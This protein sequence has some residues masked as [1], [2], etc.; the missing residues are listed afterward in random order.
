MLLML[1]AMVSSLS[2]SFSGTVQD[3]VDD[4]IESADMP[5]GWITTE[6]VYESS[7]EEIK[8]IPGVKSV[9]SSVILPVKTTLPSGDEF[10]LAL[11]GVDEKETERFYIK[12]ETLTWDD[13]PEVWV[14]AYFAEKNGVKPGNEM[15]L[16][17]GQHFEEKV[18][19]RGLVSIPETMKCVR[20]ETSWG[21]SVGYGYIYMS[22]ED[23]D[24]LF[25]MSGKANYWSIRLEEGL[26][27]T[28]RQK[29]MDAAGE[30]FGDKTLD[31]LLYDTSTAKSFIDDMMNTIRA[32]CDSFP[33]LIF[34]VG[35]FFM[36]LFVSQV[37]RNRSKDIG[38]LVALGQSRK[39]VVLIFFRYLIILLVP[40]LIV[41]TVLG[42]ITTMIVSGL[43]VDMYT[44]P[45]V[46]YR[47]D[48][49]RYGVMILIEIV[50]CFLSCVLSTFLII[51]T[52]P[53]Q[54]MSG[55]M[56][57]VSQA[58]DVIR[59]LKIDLII[60]TG[61]SSLF[62]DRR[63]TILSI[64]AISACIFLSA[65]SLEYLIGYTDAIPRTFGKR[66]TY[67]VLIAVKNGWED[68]S[69]IENIKGV[70]KAEPVLSFMTDL[71]NGD[72]KLRVKVSA[73]R[74]NS[75]MI[76]PY[77]KDY[78]RVPLSSGVI[79]DEWTASQLGISVGD[80]V[81]IEGVNVPV[82]GI[83][84]NL[85]DR[86]E[87]ISF[88]TA[89]K[90]DYEDPDTVAV[91]IDAGANHDRVFKEIAELPGY[92]YTN[93]FDQQLISQEDCTSMVRI[94]ITSL[95][96]TAI[97][98][99]MI[100]VFIMVAL[101]ISERK[102]EFAVLIA[103]GVQDAKF[104]GMIII[105]NLVIFALAVLIAFPVARIGA[106]AMNSLMSRPSQ[107]I[108]VFDFGR[109]FAIAVGLALGYLAVGII[110]GIVKLYAIDAAVALKDD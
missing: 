108:E 95:Q 85:V 33:I 46:L 58:P 98:M 63:R 9:V 80:V 14:T 30:V 13:L 104:A 19:V 23:M 81:T 69:E 45:R 47:F 48:A 73:I 61:L 55:E 27:L 106:Q 26:S 87:Y 17:F 57:K 24:S 50:F 51:S 36:I 103:L 35:L 70:S 105:E 60:K 2:A 77:T 40:G 59:S 28:E 94:S 92:N 101:S 100:I 20:N 62:R 53:A 86:T 71:K 75:Q 93:T 102:H 76:V 8:G 72:S 34:G 68:L 66:Y 96:V 38:L 64:L 29:A 97:L 4:F 37:V 78:V 7:G 31:T 39:E 3:S 82:T 54:A 5:D 16:R 107:V 65:G 79:L 84:R 91:K 89:E 41:G 83:A 42:F 109:A 56:A 49:V 32:I 1:M 74:E 88:E 21:D 12:D 6:M 44:L 110:T 18:R 43:F 10:P 11:S 99:G 22:R 15:T 67:D 90:M 25:N 52:D